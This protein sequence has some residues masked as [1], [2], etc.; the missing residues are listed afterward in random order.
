VVA[1]ATGVPTFY[2]I[3]REPKIMLPDYRD[4][5]DDGDAMS[6]SVTRPQRGQ[7]R[8]PDGSKRVISRMEPRQPQGGPSSPA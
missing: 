4:F 8:A 2:L 1:E 6:I 5:A 7:R 3:L